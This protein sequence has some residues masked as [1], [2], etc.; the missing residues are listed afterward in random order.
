MKLIHFPLW[1]SVAIAHF[2]VNLAYPSP[3]SMSVFFSSFL[4]LSHSFTLSQSVCIVILSVSVPSPCF[5][6]RYKKTVRLVLPCW[7]EIGA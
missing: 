6:S 3:L 1:T 2:G 7:L 4:F 5:A